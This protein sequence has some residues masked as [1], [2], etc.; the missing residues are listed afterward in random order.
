MTHSSK[1]VV[2]L[3]IKKV[4]FTIRMKQLEDNIL[5]KLAVAE[6]DITEDVALIEGLEETKSISDDIEHQSKQFHGMICAIFLEK[7]CMEVIL[8]MLGIEELAIPTFKFIKMRNSLT[9]LN[10]HQASK[11][12]L[13]LNDHTQTLSHMQRLQCLPKVHLYLVSTL[14]QKLAI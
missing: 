14:I 2:G 10:L 12:H 8:Q 1:V 13:H 7:S 11:A 6:G 9:V 4:G 5:H 3:K